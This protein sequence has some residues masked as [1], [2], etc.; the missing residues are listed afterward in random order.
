MDAR[1][2]RGE[3]TDVAAEENSSI[4]GLPRIELPRG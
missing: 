2:S 1:E 4:L 3:M